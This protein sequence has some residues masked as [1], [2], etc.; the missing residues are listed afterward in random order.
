[1][2]FQDDFKYFTLFT[3]VPSTSAFN[4]A[5][6]SIIQYFGWKR[7]AI[8]RE[9]DDKLHTEVYIAFCNFVAI[10]KLTE[11]TLYESSYID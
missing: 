4:K 3:N 9:Y 2:E 5:R 10:Q 1:M 6:L 7:I 8:L 11:S